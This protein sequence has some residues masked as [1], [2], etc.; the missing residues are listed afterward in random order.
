MDDTD[1][2][3]R[4]VSVDSPEEF[5]NLLAAEPLVLAAFVTPGCGICASMEPVFGVVARAAPAV[6]AVVDASVVPELA[7]TY[8]VRKSPT[9]LVF[10]DGAAVERLDEG[11][12]GADP[13]VET[14]ESHA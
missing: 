9:L 5:E 11:F 14:L 12:Y 10:R 7:R 3:S 13:L 6:V 1:E 2:R 8:D 4:P